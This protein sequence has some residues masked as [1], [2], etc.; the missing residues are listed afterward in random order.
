MLRL[1]EAPAALRDA[2]D[3]ARRA[4]R[5]VGLVPTM[6]YLHDGHL[7]LLARAR[8]AVGEAGLV[9]VSIF[10]NP[11]QFGPGEDL[12]RY[13]RDLD[14]DVAKCE[15]SG[16]DLVFAPPEDAMYAAD[17]ETF[18]DVE[19]IS[20]G[21]CGDHRPGHFRGVCTVV[22]KLFNIVGPCA[23]V[24][25]AK[26]YQQL[27]VIRRMTRD[28]FLPVEIIGAPIVR[29]VDGLAM[30]S[31][32]AYLTA[33]QR[34]VAPALHRA[35][36]AARARAR[37]SGEPTSVADVIAEARALLDREPALAVEY[38]EV[39][40]AETLQRV[41]TATPDRVVMLVAAQLGST[42]LIDNLLL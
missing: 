40:D 21:L 36:S 37:I 1:L 28:L 17:A 41:E 34:R 23:A 20:R 19:R 9:V 6:G 38:L 30:S 26:D 2:C 10:V 24:F 5:R 25:G 39:R 32:N 8:Q 35:L 13:P 7:S 33:E 4:G 3:E 42:R 31:R 11:T 12:E 27:A 14:G 15:Q 18:V 22:S 16:A 29:E